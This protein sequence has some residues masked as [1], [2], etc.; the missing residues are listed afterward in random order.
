MDKERAFE[1]ALRIIG[2]PLAM[3]RQLDVSPATI[4]MYRHGRD[5]PLESGIG[6]EKATLGKVRLEDLCPQHRAVIDYLTI[7]ARQDE[8]QQDL[9]EELDAVS[10]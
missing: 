7:R 9:S 3:S 8:Q 2:G 1:K 6:I 4:T 10:G 5:I